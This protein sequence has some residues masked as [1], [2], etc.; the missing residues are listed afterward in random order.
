MKKWWLRC[1]G[2]YQQIQAWRLLVTGNKPA[3]CITA[4]HKD[5]VQRNKIAQFH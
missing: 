2:F 3:Y 4:I 5:L 1:N